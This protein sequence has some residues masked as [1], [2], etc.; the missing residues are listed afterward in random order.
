ME[1]YEERAIRVIEEGITEKDTTDIKLT[2]GQAHMIYRFVDET[3]E[4]CTELLK[5]AKLEFDKRI[6][7]ERYSNA[8]QIRDL[9]ADAYFDLDTTF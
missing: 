2:Y 5:D 1:T 6:L 9:M 3:M 4:T 8:K 7:N